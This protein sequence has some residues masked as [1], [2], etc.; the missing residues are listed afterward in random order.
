MSDHRLPDRL[1]TYWN[2]L[3]KE[4][5]LPDFSQFN[6][7]AVS[8]IWQSCILFTV[9]PPVEGKPSTLNFSQVGDKVREIYGKDMVGRSFTTNQRNFQGA[10]IVRHAET[11]LANPTVLTDNGQFVN[12]RSKMVKYRSCLLPFGRDAKVTHI[13]V[14]LSWREF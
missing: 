3:R 4:L 12:E 13:L 14:G 6:A 5:V 9:S 11:I 2:G 7:S 10:A 8:D 1:A